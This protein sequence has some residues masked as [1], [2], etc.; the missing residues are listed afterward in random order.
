MSERLA[1]QS[2]DGG[3]LLTRE[4]DHRV[5][6]NLQILS[7]LLQRQATHADALTAADAYRHA[8]SQIAAVADLHSFLHDAAHD[9]GRASGKVDLGGYLER[10]SG[11]VSDAHGFGALGH[12]LRVEV[13]SLAVDP[14]HARSVGLIVAELVANAVRHGFE[15]GKSG[16]VWVRSH[17]RR[18]DRAFQLSVADDGRGLPPGFDLRSRPTGFG[19][20]LV[21]MLADQMR[22]RLTLDRRPSARFLLTLPAELSSAVA[23]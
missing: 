12:V 3:E 19:L 15:P 14:D 23:H 4:A 10:L 20:R 18:A 8:A 7:S 9:G 17:R 5:R 22:A 1:R 2:S 21:L 16:T 11:H 6:N 13:E